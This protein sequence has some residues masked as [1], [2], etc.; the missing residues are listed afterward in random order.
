MLGMEARPQV[1]PP[2]CKAAILLGNVY[3]ESGTAAQPEDRKNSFFPSFGQ[4]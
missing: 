2:A 1:T 4:A 3:E